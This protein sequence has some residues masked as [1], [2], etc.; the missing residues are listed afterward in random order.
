MKARLQKKINKIVFQNYYSVPEDLVT[1]FRATKSRN[2]TWMH[3]NGVH[4]SFME[5]ELLEVE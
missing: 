5:C 1:D 4:T 2:I 3:N